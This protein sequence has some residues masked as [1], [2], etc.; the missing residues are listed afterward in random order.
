DPVEALHLAVG[1]RPQFRSMQAIGHRA[2][3]HFVDECGLP[4]PRD[5]RDAAEH[6]ERKLGVDLLEVVLRRAQDLD[7]LLPGTAPGRNRD[8]TLAGEELAREGLRHA[9]D[10]G[11]RA[12]CDN[13]P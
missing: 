1:A 9:L 5:A 8:L 4:R 7:P 11:R 2:V 3:E 12:L 6:S 13:T 10:L